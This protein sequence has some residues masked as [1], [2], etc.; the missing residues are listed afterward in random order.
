[1]FLIIVFASEKD[2]LLELEEK[3]ASVVKKRGVQIDSMNAET[4][5]IGVL[6]HTV[7]TGGRVT[8]IPL[9][10]QKWRLP[11]LKAVDESTLRRLRKDLT[12]Y[13]VQ[14]ISLIP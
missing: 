9:Q 10:R 11:L 14:E 7:V 2:K 4:E 8:R 13:E 5:Q 3:I 6:T 12:D 1:M